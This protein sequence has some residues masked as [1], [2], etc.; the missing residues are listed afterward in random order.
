[1][2]YNYHNALRLGERCLKEKL[3]Q[4][5]EPFLPVLEEILG[6]KTLRTERLGPQEIPLDL[7][8]GTYTKGRTEAF[9][10]NF[11]PIME[12]GTEFEAKYRAL[13]AAHE[14]EGIRD[15]ITVFEYLHYYYV[16]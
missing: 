5:Q 11:M 1:M 8:V 16:V 12:E 14:E 15:P 3:S 10:A 2:E 9:A 6:G 4:N 7:V 13:L